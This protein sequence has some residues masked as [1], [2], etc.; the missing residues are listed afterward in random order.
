[1]TGRGSCCGG[2]PLPQATRTSAQPNIEA[3]DKACRNTMKSLCRD[4]DWNTYT[5]RYSKHTVPTSPLLKIG[6]ESS[7]ERACQSVS[8]SVVA[9]PLKKKQK[10][11]K[12]NTTE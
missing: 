10:K 5:A 9:G 4:A 12:K 8:I 7:M 11:H 6:T 2:S 1:M 3:R